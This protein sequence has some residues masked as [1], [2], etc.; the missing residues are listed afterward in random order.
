HLLRA[1]S[2][3][4]RPALSFPRL[5]AV[6]AFVLSTAPATTPIYTLSLHDALPILERIGRR[7]GDARAARELLLQH[8]TDRAVGHVRAKRVRDRRGADVSPSPDR[9]PVRAV[10]R[11]L[12]D[13]RT[14]DDALEEPV[15]ALRGTPL[16]GVVP[17]GPPEDGEHLH[18]AEQ[19]TAAIRELG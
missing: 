18:R 2:S 16:R 9:L 12:V 13:V 8:V 14:P 10:L 11:E 3:S 19:R 17:R 6:W 15:Q 1:C 4:L 7:R 5:H